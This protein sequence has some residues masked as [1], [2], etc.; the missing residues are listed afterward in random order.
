MVKI[1]GYR[2]ELGEVEACLLELPDTEQAVVVKRPGTGSGDSSLVAFML[3]SS[4]ISLPTDP[5]NTNTS[6]NSL[7]EEEQELAA[8]EIRLA[9][10]HCKKNLPA[11]M[12]PKEI[13]FL[14]EMPTNNTG[15]VDRLHLE[16]IATET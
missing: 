11:Y 2:V 1:W 5:S 10:S 16:K 14:S 8:K 6:N 15:K 9:I 4:T 12:V 7:S 3:R 13:I